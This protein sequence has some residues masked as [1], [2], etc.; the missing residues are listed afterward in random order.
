MNRIRIL[1]P[2][3]FCCIYFATSAQELFH[4]SYNWGDPATI[5]NEYLNN[6]KINLFIKEVVEF[7]FEDDNFYEYDLEHK[8]VFI[9]SDDEVKENNK[10]Y[11]Y[12][13]QFSKVVHAKA[14]VI[15]PGNEVVELDESKMLES[16]DEETGHQYK[17]FALEG[18]EKGNIIEVI[19]VIKRNP[20]YQGRRITIQEEDPIK[21][22]EFDLFAPAN[23][24]FNFLVLNDT[25]TFVVDTLAENNHWTFYLDSVEGLEKEESAPYNLLLKQMIYKLD[26]NLANNMRDISS[27]GKASQ[28][29]FNNLYS[30]LDKADL[31]ALNKFI[32]SINTDKDS[33]IDDQI[34]HV[35]NYV[36]N[37]I[38]IVEYNAMEL[39]KVSAI[40]ENKTASAEGITRL[41]VNIYKLL[42]IDHQLVITSD[43]SKIL[44]D[45]SFEAFNFLA[46]YLLYFPETKK[47]MSPDKF[48]YR[49][50]IPPPDNTNNYGL[51]I[52]RIVL[53]EMESGL[54]KVKF[55]DP[56]GYALTHHNHYVTATINDDFTNVSLD[57]T[58]SSLGYFSAPLQ[59]YIDLVSEDV[60][61]EIAE[62]STDNYIPN[63]EL[64]SWEYENISQDVIGKEPFI[65]KYDMTNSD[66]INEAGDKYLFKVGLLIGPQQE[67]Y[68]E[69]TRR[70]PVYDQYKRTFDRELT[71]I[72]PEG[73]KVVNADDLNIFAEYVVEGQQKLLFE[74]THTYEGNEIK[75][76]IH[77]YY[78]QISYTVEEYPFYREVVNSAS[79]FNKVTLAL[80]KE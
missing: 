56:P 55:I 29:I 27:Y 15:K 76:K 32:K 8:I 68:S 17:Y 35:E 38:N 7:T 75:V 4:E 10:I 72:I 62:N 52:K 36:K 64:N 39:E 44:F 46:A 34:F 19:H 67:L 21:R 61:K 16:Y 30:T 59:P 20:D 49:Y 65:M 23:L 12:Y 9:N 25:N 37:Y 3:I 42:E 1:L 73:Y 58:T 77:E 57:V 41:L 69:K 66:L 40:V 14:R 51:F 2:I 48:E 80:E 33:P 22:Y 60:R 50:G 47:F 71:V 74:S 79:D 18:L 5:P 13:N 6:K 43:R 24:I 54:G 53:G 31:K 63:S 70:L 45:Q 26:I 78:D 11:I 28:N